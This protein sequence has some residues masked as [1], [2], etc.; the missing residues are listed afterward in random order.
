MKKQETKGI[1]MTYDIVFKK[2][3][4]DNPHL[5][6]KVLE[7]FLE[8]ENIEDIVI[9]NPDPELKDDKNSTQNLSNQDEFTKV[10]EDKEDNKP[11][12]KPSLKD[13]EFL[14]FLD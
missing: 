13:K 6:R 2:F 12:S 4:T 8:I 1:K 14:T 11:V 3:F 5:L 7:H 10:K 9:T